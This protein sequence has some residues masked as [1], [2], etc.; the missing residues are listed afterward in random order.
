[1]RTMSVALALLLMGSSA[2]AQFKAS[3]PYCRLN[4]GAIGCPP[5]IRVQVVPPETTGVD[6][7]VKEL[8]QT[9]D[10]GMR[11]GR[12]QQRL[13]QE[14]RRLALEESDAVDRRLRDS[15]DRYLYGDRRLRIEE[16][17]LALEERRLQL[18][19][20]R[21]TAEE[22]AATIRREEEQL[23]ATL[24]SLAPEI[25]TQITAFD[26]AHPGWKRYASKMNEYGAK[27][28]PGRVKTT[29]YLTVLYLLATTDQ[30]ARKVL[31]EEAFIRRYREPRLWGAHP[32]VDENGVPFP[33][34]IQAQ[35]SAFNA[36]CPDWKEYAPKM[37]EY[38]AK[39][40]SGETNVTEYL[41]L[42]YRLA[43]MDAK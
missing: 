1:M 21:V 15:V 22:L 2:N 12:E 20:G 7:L 31:S 39:L 6:P 34:E 32:V 9:W 33:P 24:A 42:L 4:P 30:E 35:Y 18:A 43:K 40:P 11:R 16:R 23:E 38:G 8:L 26:A 27:L 10:E 3:D 17:K 36:A 14:E 29:E 13:D 37:K 5:P 41:M 28:R 25:R 19:E